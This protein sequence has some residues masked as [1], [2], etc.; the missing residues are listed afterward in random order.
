VVG[1]SF[2]WVSSNQDLNA[3][4]LHSATSSVSIGEELETSRNQADLGRFVWP[5]VAATSGCVACRTG[6]ASRVLGSGP[7]DVR[8][9]WLAHLAVHKVLFSDF[10]SGQHEPQCDSDHRH[11]LSSRR[12]RQPAARTCRWCAN[13]P[14]AR[15]RSW[16]VCTERPRVHWTTCGT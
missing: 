13:L 3:V 15:R 6:L 2:A 9:G 11:H 8:L 4:T 14:S 10:F 12:H 5:P 7:P 16:G 1:D